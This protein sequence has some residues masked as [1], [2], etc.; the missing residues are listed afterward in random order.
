MSNKDQLGTDF[1]RSLVRNVSIASIKVVT[2]EHAG[3]SQAILFRRVYDNE[4][5]AE[6]IATD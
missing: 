6:V 1:L 3:Q 4:V 5:L 2:V